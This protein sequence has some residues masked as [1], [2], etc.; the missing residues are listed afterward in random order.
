MLPSNPPDIAPELGVA[1][2]C[3]SYYSSQHITALHQGGVET[4]AV[5]GAD[6]KVDLDG[7]ATA[8]YFDWHGAI[9]A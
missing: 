2:Y 5:V 6:V 8:R 7:F 3:P 9:F 4:V 1:F